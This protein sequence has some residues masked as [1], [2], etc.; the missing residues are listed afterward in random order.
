MRLTKSQT[1]LLNLLI[2]NGYERPLCMPYRTYR[3][4]LVLERMGLI[5]FSLW[6]NAK[7]PVAMWLIDIK[8]TKGE[9]K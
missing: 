7:L 9:I 5:E 2:E 1:E 3:T 4:A 8:N 6:A